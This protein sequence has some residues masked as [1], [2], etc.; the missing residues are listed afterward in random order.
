M[1]MQKPKVHV[2]IC[3]SSRINGQQKGYCHQKEGVRIVEALME[4]IE[5]N[6]LTEEVMVTNTGC[7]GICSQGPI[8]VVY[9][10]N[11]WYKEVSVQDVTEII[12]SHFVKGIPVER[13]L[14][15]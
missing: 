2:F 10:E 7:F 12:E 6:D 3:T 5:E 14:I 11:V 4:G 8:M 1:T 15:K 9:P 13:L